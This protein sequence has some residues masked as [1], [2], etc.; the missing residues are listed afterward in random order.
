VTTQ[1]FLHREA[2]SLGS[3]RELRRRFENGEVHRLRP[4][5]YLPAATWA[6]LG[7]DDRYRMTV[8]A[9]ASITA[10]G[11][12]FS[13]DS[14]AALWRLPSLGAW[15]PSAHAL[16][17]RQ[18]G[19][20][21][22]AGIRFHGLGLDDEPA[23]I[24]D[25]TITSLARTLLDVAAQPVF[26]RAVAMVDAGIRPAA[27]GEFLRDFRQPT[28]DDLLRLHENRMPYFASTRAHRVL[29]FADAKS[30]SPAESLFRCQCHALGLP[31]AELQVPFFD[32]DGLIGFADFYWP[33]LG[34]VVEVDG[35][36]KYSARRR[37]QRD[38]TIE[39]IY[40]VEKRRE[41]RL[42][43]VVEGFARP[44]MEIMRDRRRLAPFLAHHGLV[45]QHARGRANEGFSAG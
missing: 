5:V 13:H 29:L 25:V 34:L 17:P 9:A 3:D 30:G 28:R 32:D 38:L 23:V 45:P 7:T 1:L 12:Q 14:A 8:R 18:E 6:T 36:V 39:Q 11:T 40:L 27:V 22:R 24:D 19:G 2:L 15:S 10:H 31:A 4:G 44:P 16:M 35:D 37:F 41:D 42:R 21:S 26:D 20:R 43:R 33:D